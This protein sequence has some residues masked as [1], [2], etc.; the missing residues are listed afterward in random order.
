M[1]RPQTWLVHLSNT[2]VGGTGLVYGW[3]RYFAESDDPFA[4]ANH[5]WQ[6]EL[7]HAHILT[8]PLLVFAVAWVWSGHVL[9]HLRAGTRRGRRTGI[10]LVSLFFPMLFSGYLL[11]TAEGES[12]R[13]AW[14]AVHVATSA[15]WVLV[16]AVHPFLRDRSR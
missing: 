3:M 8:A 2:L 15:I 12:W 10:T 9:K 11:Q 4:I 5:P 1:T 14:I 16:A 13:T 6:P 7:Q